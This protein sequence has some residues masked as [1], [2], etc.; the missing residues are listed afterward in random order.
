VH[1]AA[2]SRA[3]VALHLADAPASCFEW[4]RMVVHGFANNTPVLS[5]RSLRSPFFEPETHYLEAS[6][7][8]FAARL[9]WLLDSDEGKAAGKTV[10]ERARAV[11]DAQLSP[12]R[13]GRALLSFLS[14]LA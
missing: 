2:A 1:A 14:Q 11:L 12:P 4:Q 13:V 10:A 8:D 9:R 6:A 7:R 5:T 3:K